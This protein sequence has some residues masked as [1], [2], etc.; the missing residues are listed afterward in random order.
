MHELKFEPAHYKNYQRVDEK[1]YLALLD[2]V[3][4]MY[5]ETNTV[6]RSII[7][8]HDRLSVTHN[9]QNL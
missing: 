5:A 6:M 2:M 1:T 3:T 8:S 9:R 7:S 4:P